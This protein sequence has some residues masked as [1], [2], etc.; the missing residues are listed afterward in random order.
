MVIERPVVTR[1]DTGAEIIASWSQVAVVW[2]H[3]APIAPPR[4][5]EILAEGIVQ[6][7][8]D[9]QVTIRW[10]PL[11]DAMSAKW[12]M[13]FPAADN[14]IV[15]NIASPPVQS[16]MGQRQ[17]IVMCKAGLNEGQ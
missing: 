8:V 10:S 4:G 9:V 12:R 3:I 16:D 5:R 17:V 15:Y 1:D 7:Q 13:R 14:P 6:D 2:A 11:I